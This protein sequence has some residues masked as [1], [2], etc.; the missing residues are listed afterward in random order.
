MFRAV[1]VPI[2]AVAA[3]SCMASPV[4]AAPR[5]LTSVKWNDGGMITRIGPLRT[6]TQ[7]GRYMKISYKAAKRKL[8]RPSSFR[9]QGSTCTATWRKLGLRLL[10]TSF[11]VVPGGRCATFL[12]AATLMPSSRV[13]WQTMN[14]L[15]IGDS[16]D[17]LQAIF[18][19][20]Y[21]AEFSADDEIHLVDYPFG[22]GDSDSPTVTAV[23][24][25][26]WTQVVG[27]RLFVGQAGD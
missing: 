6:A 23:L 19:E 1:L 20:A 14:G 17:Q 22:Y 15:R 21:R 7:S 13:R 24:D 5:G 11:G 4:S 10:W 25:Y 16:Y 8:G 9:K 2:I 12:Q 27:F 3:L 18:P 26:D